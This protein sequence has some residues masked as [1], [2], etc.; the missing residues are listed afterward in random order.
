MDLSAAKEL[1]ERLIAEFKTVPKKLGSH[2]LWNK[3]AVLERISK[4]Y[5][6]FLLDKATQGQSNQSPPPPS[7]RD[8]FIRESQP[9]E[10]EVFI[11]EWELD[12]TNEG[13]N[14]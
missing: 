14:D 5:A 3:H 1:H 6:E 13:D 2:F 10:P 12:N 9:P 7:D 8:R 11:P 4:V